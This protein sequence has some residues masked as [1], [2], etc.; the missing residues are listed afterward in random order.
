GTSVV[1][2]ARLQGIAPA[3]TVVIGAT[4]H[5]LVHG[6]F[7]CKP[8]GSLRVK[9]IAARIEAWR[10][11]TLLSSESRFARRQTS[12]LTPMSGRAEE[13][14]R[15]QALWRQAAAGD[16]RVVTVIG[17]P[18]IGKSRLLL[19]FRNSLKQVEH[20][21]IFLQCSP[22]HINTPLAPVIDQVKRNAR[23][24]HA[25]APEEM[26]AKLKSL[27]T[28]SVGDPHPLL[29]YYGAILSIPAHGDYRPA[30]VS[31]PG[32]REKLLKAIAAVPAAMARQRPVL[33]I[34]EDAH[35]LDPTSRRLASLVMAGVGPARV[36]CLISSRGPLEVAKPRGVSLDSITLS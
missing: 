30:A 1:V 18:G 17:E 13:L 27:L 3:N 36:L 5:G 26:L 4:T 15:L 34:I 12:P 10:V 7:E 8:L 29:P 19:E 9:G 22:L 14:G 28:R 6:T 16:G 24:D 31:L 21:T 33:L 25:D 35:W 11:V 20:H 32:E 2:A 23:I